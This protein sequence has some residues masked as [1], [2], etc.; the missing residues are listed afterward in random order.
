MKPKS[1]AAISRL[2]AAS[3]LLLGT[4]CETVQKYSLTYRLWDTGDLRKWSE[5]APD[6][7]LALFEATNSTDV[8]VQYDALS[9]QRSL[10]KRRAYYLRQNEARVAAG[11]KPE[12]VSLALADGLK[13][14]AVLPMNV[15]VTNPPPGPTAYAVVTQDGRAFA[16]YRPMKPES[17]FD[18]PVYAETAGT[19]TRIM[20]TPFTVAGDAVMAGAA[21]AVVGFLLWV[22]VGAPN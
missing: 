11:K 1:G 21:A 6:P 13:P 2:A 4:G 7:N 5:P 19:P 20:L 3:L 15:A 17:T 9:Q 12:L 14:I 16:L 22:S 18:L 10:V 8:L